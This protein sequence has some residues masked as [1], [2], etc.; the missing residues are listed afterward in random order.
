[1][2]DEPAD[3]LRFAV[4]AH[5]NGGVALAT[6]VE[7]R[8]GAAR[9][10]GAQVAVASNGRY[11]GYVSGGCVEAAVAAEALDAMEEGRDRI[12]QFGDG[13]TF[14]DIVLP[15]GGGMA[16]AIHL[17]R[18][19]DPLREVLSQVERRL[20]SALRYTPRTGKLRVE[21]V[22][23]DKACWRGD[24]FLTAFRPRTRLLLSGQ[25]LEADAVARLGRA[26]GFDIH[27]ADHHMAAEQVAAAIDRFTAVALLHHDLDAEAILLDVALQS[28]AF[29]IG[30]LGATRTHRRRVERL[31][32]SF[33]EIE[34]ARI[35]APIGV[36]GPARDS[37][38]LALS[39]LADVAAVRHLVHP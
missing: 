32:A 9:S 11:C 5:R 34:I 23:P 3:I 29:Y 33:S 35:R 4:D 28:P 20:P 8:G 27:R 16:V 13:S 12:V 6:L 19:D 30:A 31:K 7:V 15:C 18:S 36:F 2:S 26:A 21:A 25:G 22:G 24:D 37:S 39:I 10:L 14:F 17:L 1:M 38:S